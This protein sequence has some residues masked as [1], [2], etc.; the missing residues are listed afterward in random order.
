MD[1]S[2]VPVQMLPGDSSV[3]RSFSQVVSCNSNCRSLEEK[4]EKLHEIIEERNGKS[5][6]EDRNVFSSRN[7]ENDKEMNV[8]QNGRKLCEEIEKSSEVS[9]RM[10]KIKKL[11]TNGQ[12]VRSEISKI[13]KNES[14]LNPSAKEFRSHDKKNCKE[15]KVNH[16]EENE[17]K[18]LEIANVKTSMVRSRKINNSGK[19]SSGGRSSNSVLVHLFEEVFKS[20][21]PNFIGRRV[22]LPFNKFNIPLWR[23]LLVDYVDN[24]ICEFLEFGFPLDFNKAVVLATDERRNHKGAKEHPEYVS[25]YLTSEVERSRVAGPFKTNPLSIPIM[26]SPLNTVPKASS[27]ERR[28]IVDLS[29]PLGEGSVNSGISKEYYLEKKIE[30]H[31]ASIEDVCEMVLSLGSGALIFKRDLR[32]AY[33]QFPVDPSDYYLLGYHWDNQYF[34]DTVLAMGQRNAGVG[35]SRVTNAVM[36]IFSKCGHQGVSYLDDLIGVS[37]SSRG[38]QIVIMLL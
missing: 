4:S 13:V 22:S 33:R 8:G 31:Y 17:G 24:I 7:V 25:N 18:K 9:E 32:Q 11:N 36:H 21:Q 23:D 6:M 16:V 20:G 37:T 38:I 34:F 15:V 30:L 19:E 3:I 26:V 28:I 14:K 27:D 1:S 10:V 29:W 5:T 35:C 2:N 12:E